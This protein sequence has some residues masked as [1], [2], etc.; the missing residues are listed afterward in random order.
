MWSRDLASTVG[1][2][3][4]LHACEHYYVLFE[5]VEGLH[6]DL[7]VLRDYDA[8][9]Y[10]KYDAGK[11]LLG[12]FEP[13]AK[14]WG[15]GGI[16]E[17][18]CFD[19]IAGDFDHFEPVLHDAM[20]RFPALE[21]AGI[22]KFFCGPES[23]TPD[24][25]YH[26]GEAPELKNCFVAA[27]LNSIGLQ[28]AGGVGKVTAEWIR[29]GRPPVDL[30][31][32][33]VR[34]NMPFQRNR[35]YLQ[36]RVGESLGLLYATHYP[37]RQYETA[38][39]VRKAAIHDRLRTA[40]AC[41]GEAYGWERP[42][43]Y[44][45]EGVEPVYDYSYGRQNWFEHS[46]AEHRAVREGVALFDQSSFAKFRFE[47]R[48]TVAVLNR[49]CANNIDV[50]PGK[51]VYTQWLN[52]RGGIEADLTV[53]RLTEHAFMIVSAAET[54]VRDFY[55]LKRH[56]P[57]DAHC[58]LTNV[59]SGMG[60]I[61]IMGPKARDLLQSLTP[62]D[63]SHKGFPFATSREIEL[64][65]CYVRASRITFVGELGWELYIPTEFM[66]DIY[67]RIVAAGAEWGLAHAGYHALNSLRTEKA[68]RHWS[69]DI[70]DEDSPLEAGLDFVVKWD[71]PGGFVGR[72]ALLQQ[73][74]QGLSRHL[75]QLRL[76][77][78]EPL[79]YH[80]EPIWRD[81]ILV[82]HITSGAYGHTLGGAVGLGYVSAIP[83][84]APEAVLEGIYEV[85][86]ACEKI[87]A[88]VS[89]RPLYDPENSK[90]RS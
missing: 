34:R 51:V 13:S 76:K 18:F 60:V 37:Y 2:N 83:A 14:P 35:R 4:P 70:T 43:W 11:L 26:L 27:G 72:E 71:K 73:R 48:D 62:D 67:D 59:T 57:D 82:G 5:S 52:E 41:H 85:E 9:T 7:P 78:P 42:N 8:C 44:A 15:M 64:G 88:E 19:E 23:F 30:W 79:I 32:V 24:V 90:I 39:G 84:D 31:E 69:H 77:D 45:P 38:R 58:V 21:R 12:A 16:S 87:T 81:G 33:D 36:S 1:V 74:E 68:Y 75:V 22:Q 61:S 25:R 47:G 49:I 54:E 66:Q 65:F 63:M 89:L 6:P 80:N 55:W 20:K 28:S 53:T 50:A 10:Y 29:D 86:V 56:I 40:G 46:A 17:D 3:L